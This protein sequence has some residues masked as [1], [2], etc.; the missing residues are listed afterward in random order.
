[1]AREMLQPMIAE[2]RALLSQLQEQGK[3]DENNALYFL[4]E[5]GVGL[6]GAKALLAASNITL[7]DA[8]EWEL[9]TKKAKQYDE[10]MKKVKKEAD[11][12]D[13]VKDNKDK[14]QDKDKDKDGSPATTATPSPT[15]CTASG[16]LATIVELPEGNEKSPE[17]R[18]A[19]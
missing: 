15:T 17:L 7:V 1:M 14:D 11:C 12:E 13:A 19:Y 5:H 8:A 6:D 2:L 3:D 18:P 10:E 9:V 16:G 4:E